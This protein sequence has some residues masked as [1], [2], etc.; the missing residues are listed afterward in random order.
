VLP[1][2]VPSA[3]VDYD[4]TKSDANY[5]K[6]LGTLDLG[7]SFTTGD[8]TVKVTVDGHLRRTIQVTQGLGRFKQLQPARQKLSPQDWFAGDVDSDNALTIKDYNIL[9][10]CMP[11]VSP[12][13]GTTCRLNANYAT[14]SHL[15]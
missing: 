3:K 8:Y 4:T 10:S 7:T 15:L 2:T 13:G 5:G 1:V 12:D 14:R 6:F 11:D 9:M